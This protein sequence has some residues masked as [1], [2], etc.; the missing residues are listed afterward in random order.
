MQGLSDLLSAFGMSFSA[1]I[2][3]D[4]GNQAYLELR[5]TTWLGLRPPPS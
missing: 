1:H 5:I 3:S 4:A 2:E